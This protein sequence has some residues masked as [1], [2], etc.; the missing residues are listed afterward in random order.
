[1]EVVIVT[2]LSGAGK[3]QAINCMEDI[4]YYCIDNLPPALMNSFLELTEK[5]ERKI[6]KAGFVMD[7]RGGKFFGDFEELFRNLSERGIKY[8]I[9]YLEA[10]DA[11]LI[12]RYKETRRI[13]PL[14]IAGD[15]QE[16]IKKEKVLLKDLRRKADFIIDTSNMNN[17]VL[18]NEIF[19]ILLEGK[20]EPA[21]TITVQSFGFKYG[22]SLDADMV[23]D[24]R[25]LPN[26]FYLS[27]MKKLTG[28]SKVVQ[29]YVMKFP[30]S[31]EF[32]T[33]VHELLEMMIPKYIEE[34]KS[35]LVVAFGC[36]GGQHR[37]VTMANVFS[38]VLREAGHR[39]ITI[40][41]DL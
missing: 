16:G 33:R 38:E 6:E 39:V 2:G 21:F 29:D 23:Y 40:H 10:S 9:L 4:G 24:M 15:T 17:A 13:H 20:R 7:I 3:S 30:E 8:K 41:R 27:S 19:K 35:H 36:T 12:R 1:M 5:E 18:K 34:G 14:S 37:S 22:I 32:V 26:P 31:R 28:N 11:V 25:F